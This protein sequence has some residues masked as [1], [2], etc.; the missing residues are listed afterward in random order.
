[1]SVKTKVENY[2]NYITGSSGGWPTNTNI[3]IVG[4]MDYL[5]ETGSND[6]YFVEPNTNIGLD[7]SILEQNTL[8]NSISDYANEQSCN[9]CYVYGVS[10]GDRQ[11]PTTYQ[12]TLISSSFARHNMTTN[13][14]Y[15]NNTSHTYFSQR[16]Q[17]QYTGSFHLFIQTPWYSDDNLKSI[18]SGSFNKTTFRSLLSSSPESGSLIPLFDSSSP[19]TNTNNPDFI[20]KNPSVD[21]GFIN[22]YKMYDWNGSNSRVT[23]AIASAS[24]AG[25]LTET[26]IVMSGS[27]G[28][29]DTGRFVFLTTPTKQIE[30]KDYVVSLI[31]YKSDGNDGY[32]I[33]SY[34]RTTA[35]GSLI[36]MFDGSTKQVQDVEVGD[37]VK[38]YWPDNMS[39]SDIDYMDYSI[40]NL[41][42]SFSGS[43][44]VGLSQDERSEYYLLNGT[45]RLSKMNSI[46]TDSDYFVK[47]EGT[48][49]WKKT[50]DISVGDYLLQGDGTELEVTSLTE[51]AATT[52]FYSLDVEDI[53]TYF[54]SDILVHKL[55]K[56]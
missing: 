14:E 52:T 46:T 19:T 32:T 36:D 29:I 24:S 17:N 39:L 8:F 41:T 33:K 2:L 35:S 51:E 34:G 26:F 1:M 53:D 31:S 15:N 48:W 38:S 42:G 28:H 50:R 55:P 10:E 25:H 7:G 56:R 9:T 30:L 43:I 3:G 12:Q 5:V 37:I 11:N 6:I 40:T 22:N 4:M 23:N 54:Q 20:V 16:G 44:V 47:S 21:G 45:K 27:N 13:F 18:V 49:T